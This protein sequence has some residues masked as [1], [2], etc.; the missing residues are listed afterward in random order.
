MIQLRKAKI[1][2]SVQILEFYRNII[3]TTNDEFNP[4][5]MIII[6]IWNLLKNQF[7]K[8]S[9]TFTKLIKR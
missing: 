8:E 9:Y 7:Q 5:G 2:E 6:L 1:N 3:N 4:N